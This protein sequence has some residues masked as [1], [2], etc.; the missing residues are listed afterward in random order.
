M[1]LADRIYQKV[2]PLPEPLAREVLDFVDFLS[3]RSVNAE[4]DN[5][6]KAQSLSQAARDWDNSDDEIWNDRPAL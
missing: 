1:T 2:R 3:S 5:L 4:T 6:I